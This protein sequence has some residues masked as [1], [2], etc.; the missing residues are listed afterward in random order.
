MK[1]GHF[2]K[3]TGKCFIIS[4]DQISQGRG[5]KKSDPSEGKAHAKVLR[6]EHGTR[7]E[8]KSTQCGRCRGA[9]KVSNSQIVKTLTCFGIDFTRSFL[10]LVWRMQLRGYYGN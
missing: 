9:S 6:A 1:R 4:P 7:E 10:Y 3:N 8:V 5:E 2:G